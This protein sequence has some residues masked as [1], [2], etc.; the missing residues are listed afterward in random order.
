MFTCGPPRLMEMPTLFSRSHVPRGS[1]V[2]VI[3][4]HTTQ[5]EMAAGGLAL[6]STSGTQKHSTPPHAKHQRSCVGFGVSRLRTVNISSL[7][8]EHRENHA[9][10]TAHLLPV[11]ARGEQVLICFFV[12][13][14][15]PKL[16]LVHCIGR[17][18]WKVN[19]M[20]WK[21]VKDRRKAVSVSDHGSE[22]V[23]ERQ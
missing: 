17:S 22:K 18:Q 15:F 8:R 11:A 9:V 14:C 5:I 3:F 4:I 16:K 1:T 12:C 13:L 23:A 10:P 2:M 6:K 19:E 7:E 21:A 20:E